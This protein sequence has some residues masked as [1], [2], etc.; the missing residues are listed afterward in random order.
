MS[1][2]ETFS[3]GGP[4]PVRG[5]SGKAPGYVLFTEPKPRTSG[6]HAAPAGSILRNEEPHLLPGIGLVRR[7][8]VEARN[9]R[10]LT[11][12]DYARASVKT[13]SAPAVSSAR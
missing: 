9:D 2:S 13:P 3:L 1:E 11:R 8:M 4:I 10:L 5:P 6:R 12:H 7:I